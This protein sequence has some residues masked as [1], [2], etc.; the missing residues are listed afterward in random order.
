MPMNSAKMI[1][2]HSTQA[3]AKKPKPISGRLVNTNGTIAQWM[4]QSVEAVM[5]I[6]SR[7][8][9]NLEKCMHKY[10]TNATLMHLLYKI[11]RFDYLI[12]L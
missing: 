2:P 3:L 12:L 11:L 9:E 4:A 10:T 1:M 6:L 7:P 5:P 8:I